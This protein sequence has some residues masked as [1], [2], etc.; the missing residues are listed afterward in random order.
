MCAGSVNVMP[1]F[2]IS[3]P[4]YYS[5]VIEILINMRKV[6]LKTCMQGADPGIHE[7]RSICVKVRWFALLV[8][9]IFINHPM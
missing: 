6:I 2:C 1:E 5:P 8:L 4:L 7:R 9:S 3:L